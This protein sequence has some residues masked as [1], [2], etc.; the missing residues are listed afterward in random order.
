MYATSVPEY[1]ETG[2]FYEKEDTNPRSIVKV[3]IILAATAIFSAVFS[4]GFFKLLAHQDDQAEAAAAPPRWARSPGAQ[5]PVPRLQATVRDANGTL[6]SPALDLAAI[7][8]EEQA[9]LASY[10]WVD[11]PAGTVRIPID[12]AMRLYVEHGPAALPAPSASPVPAAAPAT[13]PVAAPAPA[14]PAAAPSPGGH[15]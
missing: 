7:R 15:R 14:A 13:A 3:G 6:T 10:A 4:L 2:V 5:P 9:T 11:K 1:S 8:R 12:L